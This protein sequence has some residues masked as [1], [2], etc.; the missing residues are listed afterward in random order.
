MTEVVVVEEAQMDH[1]ELWDRARNKE[2]SK[3]ERDDLIAQIR[4]IGLPPAGTPERGLYL[5]L[6]RR[7]AGEPLPPKPEPEPEPVPEPEPEHHGP[8]RRSRTTREQMA[9]IA[10]LYADQTTPLEEIKRTYGIGDSTLYRAV[11]LAGLPK[12]TTAGAKPKELSQAMT[13]IVPPRYVQQARWRV[14][15]LAVREVELDA[16][17]IF[18]AVNQAGEQYGDVQGFHVVKVEQV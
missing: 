3:D 15:F 4:E 6:F 17:N 8:G 10:A 5:S 11:K 14:S 2:L 7:R 13:V 16:A 18:D 1:Q 9:E 12:R